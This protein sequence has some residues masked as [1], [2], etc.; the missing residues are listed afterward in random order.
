M[1][2]EGGEMTIGQVSAVIL[3]S[4]NITPALADVP[5]AV[6]RKP[7]DAARRDLFIKILVRVTD[8]KWMQS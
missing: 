4:N 1:A 8:I 2:P 3:P 7:S 5:M 6:N